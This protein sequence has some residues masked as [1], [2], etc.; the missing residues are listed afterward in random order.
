MYIR[1]DLGY[2]WPKFI[3][4]LFFSVV[5]EIQKLKNKVHPNVYPIGYQVSGNEIENL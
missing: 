5:K 3:F 4:K 2:T 1:V